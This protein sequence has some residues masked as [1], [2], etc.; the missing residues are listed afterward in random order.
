MTSS[1]F[2]GLFFILGS[3]EFLHLY[4]RLCAISDSPEKSLEFCE[5]S[6]ERGPRSPAGTPK[7]RT[8]PTP[9]TAPAGRRGAAAQ[10][11]G[12][13]GRGYPAAATGTQPAQGG[14]PA[15]GGVYRG[16]GRIPAGGYV[17]GATGR[18]WRVG[19]RGGRIPGGGATGANRAAVAP[20]WAAT[21]RGATPAARA[22]YLYRGAAY[23]TGLYRGAAAGGR[24]GTATPGGGG[25]PGG[26]PGVNMAI[27]GAACDGYTPFGVSA[28]AT[29]RG[30]LPG[31]GAEIF[32]RR[33]GYGGENPGGYPLRAYI[34]SPFPGGAARILFRQN[35]LKM[36]VLFV[37][38]LFPAFGVMNGHAGRA[39]RPGSR[40]R[41]KPPGKG[42]TPY[43]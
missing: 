32:F 16:R 37:G 2:K 9:G 36:I 20:T 33:G 29:G 24:G 19:Y 31:G 22:S 1:P 4:S 38:L 35:C 3:A 18:T 5:I 10:Y 23:R 21:G 30:G 13:A 8:T 17:R 34:R 27:S 12:G 6:H 43:A 42:G 14:Y 26:V 11:P 15:A 40:G 28:A 25:Y 39:H 41:G 7:D